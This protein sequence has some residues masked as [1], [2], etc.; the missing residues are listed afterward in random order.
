MDR[1]KNDEN[2]LKDKQRKRYLKLYFQFYY[3]HIVI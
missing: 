3:S 1:L 2:S